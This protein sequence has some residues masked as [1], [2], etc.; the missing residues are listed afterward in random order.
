MKGPKVSGKDYSMVLEEY[1]RKM[2]NKSNFPARK[3]ADI[4]QAFSLSRRDMGYSNKP[5]V[6]AEKIKGK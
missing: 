6:K 3:P 2:G 4:S 5:R 1:E